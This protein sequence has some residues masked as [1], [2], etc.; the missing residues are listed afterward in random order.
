VFD[1]SDKKTFENLEDFI[2][3]FNNK[4]VN[5]NKLLFLVG[6][7]ADKEARQVTYDEGEDF[8]TNY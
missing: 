5:P 4:N 3:N 6:N 7:K 8:A 1:V 2:E